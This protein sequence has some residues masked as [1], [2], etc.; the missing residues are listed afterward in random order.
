MS[1][2]SYFW[3][4]WLWP[5]FDVF[6]YNTV[7]NKSSN[8]GTEPWHW[9]FTSALPRSCLAAYPLAILSPMALSLMLR[10]VCGRVQG[11]AAASRFEAAM[12]VLVPA[13]AF[14]S[15]YSFLPHKELRFIFYAVPALNVAAALWMG[16]LWEAWRT[17][18]SLQKGSGFKNNNAA[19][20]MFV[21]LLMALV[22]L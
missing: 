16:A 2:D 6:F 22:A 17:P 13:L 4:R 10:G 19:R 12:C 20:N 18:L 1:V 3:K 9:Y 5:E 11:T 21:A 7:E 8:W 15:L 14:V